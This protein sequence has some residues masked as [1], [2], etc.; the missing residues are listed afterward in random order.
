MQ[1]KL[2]FNNV[3]FIIIEKNDTCSLV[4]KANGNRIAG[5]I[6][7]FAYMDIWIEYMGWAHDTLL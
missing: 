1:K 7:Y 6:P 3:I 5:M 4:L 2:Q